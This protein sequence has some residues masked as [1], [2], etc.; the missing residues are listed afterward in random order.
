M[1]LSSHGHANAQNAK[2][3]T[4]YDLCTSEEAK[5]VIGELLAE[6]LRRHE[7]NIAN[8]SR[9]KRGLLKARLFS[10]ADVM[11]KRVLR[12]RQQFGQISA[13]GASTERSARPSTASP[14]SLRQLSATQELRHG[15][16]QSAKGNATPTAKAS[17]SGARR[18]GR[19]SLS[20]RSPKASQRRGS[21]S[22]NGSMF[23]VVRR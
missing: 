8:I 14:A 22:P 20:V 6:D 15:R 4:A 10:G 21:F 7:A 12:M 18:W 2:R 16:P 1:P 23:E 9:I 17:E 5:N 3:K 13:S 19:N 11:R